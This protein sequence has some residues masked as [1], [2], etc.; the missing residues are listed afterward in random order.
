VV[1]DQVVT[2]THY[3]A[4]RFFTPDARPLNRLQPGPDDRLAHEQPACLHANMDLYKWSYKLH[5]WLP[6]EQLLGC[7]ELA[8]RARTLDMR[9]SPYDLRHLGY[10]PIP[11]ETP[12]GRRLYTDAQRDIADAAAPLRTRLATSLRTLLHWL[13]EDADEAREGT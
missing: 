5:P 3:D 1:A 11:I 2:C 7:F 13:G 9:A 4:F 12:D 8:L 6:A 10:S